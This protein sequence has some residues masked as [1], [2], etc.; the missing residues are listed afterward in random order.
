MPP[1]R[2]L[3][4]T[5]CGCLSSA[6]RRPVRP[7]LL[8]R[9]HHHQHQYPTSSS[10][11]RGLRFKSMASTTASP[12]TAGTTPTCSRDTSG[13]VEGSA[14]LGL[15][16]PAGVYRYLRGRWGLEKTIDYKAG[17]MAGTWRGV[18]TFSPKQQQACDG[19]NASKEQ[20]EQNHGGDGQDKVDHDSLLFLRYREQ[21]T[22]RVNGEGAG[23]EAGQRL[24]YDCS[25]PVV[26]VHFVDDP[27]KPDALRFFHEL[28]FQTARP[29]ETIAGA[30]TGGESSGTGVAAAAGASFAPPPPPRAEFEH[31]C[32]RDMYRGKVEVVGPNEFK[33]SWHVTGP[34]KDGRINA[35]FKRTLSEED[36]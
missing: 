16:T 5:V 4:L 34:Q 36:D 28:D 32:V 2:L 8:H 25:G 3:A 19:S 11:V 17:G 30:G 23:F 14:L 10:A 22:F 15:D 9:C 31:L 1:V 27:K 35:T 29:C 33:T 18:A 24:V 26:R 6:L 12:I 20:G 21:G 13:G 7:Q